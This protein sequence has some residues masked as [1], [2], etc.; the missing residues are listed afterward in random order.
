MVEVHQHER[1]G[2]LEAVGAL[3]FLQQEP[4]HLAAIEQAGDIVARG[5]AA[6]GGSQTGSRLN[7]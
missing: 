7:S 5:E 1:E 6:Q 3:P 2:T 4:V